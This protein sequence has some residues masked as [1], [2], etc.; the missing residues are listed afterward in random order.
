[1]FEYQGEFFRI[2]R[3]REVSFAVNSRFYVVY[4]Q[5]L[6]I[7]YKYWMSKTLESFL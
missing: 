4:D 5:G 2:P 1:M 3:S 7:M 6:S